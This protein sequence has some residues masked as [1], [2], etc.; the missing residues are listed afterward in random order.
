M[1]IPNH[2]KRPWN[3]Q[4][5]CSYSSKGIC[6]LSHWYNQWR[7]VPIDH[8]RHRVQAGKSSQ[9]FCSHL[10][11]EKMHVPHQ[12]DEP[13]RGSP[14]SPSHQW[15]GPQWSRCKSWAQRGPSVALLPCRPTPWI[16]SPSLC[17]SC[18]PKPKGYKIKILLILI[19]QLLL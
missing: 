9:Q 1:N 18:Q 15:S 6:P 7:S 3:G 4:L 11:G 10:E 2:G 12:D 5:Q 17:D 14:H 8:E 19:I 16:S 13:W